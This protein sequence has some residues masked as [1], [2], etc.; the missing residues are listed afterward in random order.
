MK[1]QDVMTRNPET[2]SADSSII[3]VA[4]KMKSLNVGAIPVVDGDKPIGII[5]DRDIVVRGIAEGKD[6]SSLK[7]RDCMSGDLVFCHPNDDITS[8][9]QLMQQKKIRRLLVLDDNNQHVVGIVSLG[10]LAT[11]T[12]RKLAGSTIEK[13]SEP[14]RP[15]RR[16]VA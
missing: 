12:D 1:L 14:S 8:A 11:E 15:N 16:K 6:L 4:N 3:D 10:D 13:V 7:A 9:A 2:V 5:T